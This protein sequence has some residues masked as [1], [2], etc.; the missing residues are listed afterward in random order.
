MQKSRS[1]WVELRGV[2][3][4][5]Y[6][7]LNPETLELQLIRGDRDMYFDIVSTAQ[8]REAVVTRVGYKGRDQKEEATG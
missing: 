7:R 8:M 6:G 3:R 5:L 2:D 4:K 1:E